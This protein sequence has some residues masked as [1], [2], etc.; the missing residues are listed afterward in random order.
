MGALID[1][2]E[3]RRLQTELS[4]AVRLRD[5]FLAIASHE[6]RTPLTM[7]KLQVQGLT[8]G[9]RGEGPDARL[10]LK[11]QRVAE[12]VERMVVM[13]NELLDVSRIS[14]G[15]ISLELEEV[16]L[17]EMVR[18]VVQRL[19]PEIRRSRSAVVLDLQPAVTGQWDPHRLDQVVCNLLSNAIK[20]GAGKE[21]RV[22]L[23]ANDDRA[24]RRVVDQGIGIPVEEQGRIFQRFERAVSDRHFGGFGLGLWIVRRVLEAFGGSIRVESAPGAGA[25]F[26]ANLP[27]QPQAQRSSNAG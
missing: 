19:E 18:E 2:T 5:D 24:L 14:S 12:R 21:V 13:V 16:D 15:K 1:V 22:Q 10:G 7:M 3:Q 17:T 11:L 25:S 8:R 27:R 20:Y 4:E 26:E 23:E 6:L 9:V